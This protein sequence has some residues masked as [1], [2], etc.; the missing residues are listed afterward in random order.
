MPDKL[1]LEKINALIQAPPRTGKSTLIG[2]LCS[3]LNEKGY[4]IGGIVTPEIK[5]KNRR[6]G[7]WVVDLYTGKKDILAHIDVKSKF[8]VSKYGVDIN[9]FDAIA[10]SS[11]S[12]ATEY[13]DLIVIDEIGKMELFSEKFQ[14]AV[15][16]GLNS[17]KPVVG[18]MGMINHPFVR[19]LKSRSDVH[20][21]TL[22]RGSREYIYQEICTLLGLKT[23]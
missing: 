19:L 10:P 22:D 4:K 18:T 17:R 5:E 11:I 12:S 7:F 6:V 16:K 2:K 8:K 21:L 9:S 20:F 13:C 14:D 1:L 23:V 15:E 3:M